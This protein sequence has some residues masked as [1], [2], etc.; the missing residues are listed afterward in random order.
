[1]IKSSPQWTEELQAINK[2]FNCHTET[3]RQEW[4]PNLKSNPHCP[5]NQILDTVRAYPLN[6][7]DYVFTKTA[8]KLPFLVQ[9]QIFEK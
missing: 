5:A 9:V 6:A 2:N 3:T 1:V 4:L 8:P 7:F